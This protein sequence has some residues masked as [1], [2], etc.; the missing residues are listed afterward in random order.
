MAFS[1]EALGLI[2]ACE[3]FLASVERNG[4]T[5][6]DRAMVLFYA[7]TLNEQVF[8]EENRPTIRHAA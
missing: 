6:A 3:A 1:N 2:K 8:R 4:S 5:E 7:Q